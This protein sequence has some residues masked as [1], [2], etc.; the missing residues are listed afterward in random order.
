MAAT[1]YFRTYGLPI[2]IAR[3]CNLYGP[4]T[5]PTAG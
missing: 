4:A 1:C 5:S 2:A 3:F